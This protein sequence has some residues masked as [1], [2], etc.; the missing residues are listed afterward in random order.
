MI[1]I[2]IE[3]GWRVTNSEPKTPRCKRG[4]AGNQMNDKYFNRNRNDELQTQN[5]KPLVANEGEHERHF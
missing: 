3:T 1:N 2:L 5:H 4:G